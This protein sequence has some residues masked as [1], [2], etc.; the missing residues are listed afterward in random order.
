MTQY[1]LGNR[2]LKCPLY[3]PQLAHS[4]MALETVNR[5]IVGLV[6]EGVKQTEETETETETVANGVAIK[7]HRYI[8]EHEV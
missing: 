5:P 8:H 2:S 1:T 4:R 6:L 3:H 7:Q